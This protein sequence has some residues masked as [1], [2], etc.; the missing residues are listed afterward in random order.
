MLFRSDT[1]T[2]LVT[3]L[4]SIAANVALAFALVD[5][6]VDGEPLG[7]SGIALANS[8]ATL[9]EAVLLIAL[10]QPRIRMPLFS[11]AFAT[12]RQLAAALCMG[13]AIFGYV[14][15]TNF[16][17]QLEISKIGLALQ[18]LSA[19]AVA[20]ASYLAACW[21]LRVGELRFVVDFFRRRL[22]PDRRPLTE[23]PA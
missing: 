9:A 19:F 12:M 2:P 1:R 15:L 8:I 21:L 3:T 14:H 5:A 16:T 4:A 7:I 20:A 18:L 13:I 22:T 6:R 23:P 17:V 10:L 11:V